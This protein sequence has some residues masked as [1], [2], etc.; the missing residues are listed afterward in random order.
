MRDLIRKYVYVRLAGC[1]DPLRVPGSVIHAMLPGKD[2][3]LC[4]RRPRENSLGWLPATG[5]ATCP[6]CKERL[7]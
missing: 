5:P 1:L 4:S 3:T 7:R 2:I 6:R